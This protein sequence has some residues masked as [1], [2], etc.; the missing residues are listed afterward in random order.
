MGVLLGSG[1]EGCLVPTTGDGELIKAV[2]RSFAVVSMGL[3]LAEDIN[4]LSRSGYSKLTK[5]KKIN[6]SHTLFFTKMHTRFS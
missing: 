2:L 4:A 6:H 3:E 1:S 5:E